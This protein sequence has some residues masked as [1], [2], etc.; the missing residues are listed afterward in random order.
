MIENKAQKLAFIGVDWGT[1]SFRAW[2]LSSAGHVMAESRSSEGMLYC[3]DNG[4][5]PVLAAH[6]EKLN[7][8][9]GLPVLICGMAGARQGWVEAPYLH[10]PTALGS[11]HFGS[12]MAPFL[13]DVR[14][15]PGLAQ[16]DKNRPD[17][18]RGEETQLLGAIDVDFS[19]IVCIPGTHS[20]WV[21]IVDG[22]VKS[23]TTYMTG[24]LFSVLSSHSILKHAIDREDAAV[25]KSSAFF[26]GVEMGLENP[27][28]LTSS[29][30]A[31]RA[32]QLLGFSE[33]ENGKDWLSGLIIGVEIADAVK[34]VSKNEHFILIGS[35]DLASLYAK[36]M[37]HADYQPV[38]KDAEAASRNGLHKAARNLWNM[39]K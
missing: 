19:G 31:L 33:R 16:T 20:K 2:L 14:I 26:A 11:L 29:L 25:L 28:S 38:T 24:E 3:A 5:A 36:A 9:A 18:M 35:G 17:V 1:S 27:G 13:A 12:V 22:V 15:L 21:R 37:Q 34:E 7:A 10:T 30:F 39:D 6:L 8:P 4:F 32:S 23:F